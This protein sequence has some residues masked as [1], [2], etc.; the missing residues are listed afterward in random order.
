MITVHKGLM[1]WNLYKNKYKNKN[2]SF[3]LLE[4][5]SLPLILNSGNKINT[6]VDLSRT[7][8]YLQND[9]DKIMNTNNINKD[10]KKINIKYYLSYIIGKQL[11]RYEINSKLDKDTSKS[12]V[13][14]KFIDIPN[15]MTDTKKQQIIEET[16]NKG[17][18]K[19][20]DSYIMDEYFAEE[21][22]ITDMY[23][24]IDKN[25]KLE[26]DIN[27]LEEKENILL[28]Q[29]KD[30][31]QLKAIDLL[32]QI[33]E[34]QLAQYKHSQELI[35]KDN[36]KNRLL[37]EQLILK[38][39]EIIKTNPQN[40]SVILKID[41]DINK[42]MQIISERF[43]SFEESL[44]HQRKLEKEI[45]VKYELYKLDNLY[46]KL[47]QIQHEK[48]I[49]LKKKSYVMA[50]ESKIGKTI[51]DEKMPRNE[52]LPIVNELLPIVKIQS[53]LT[54]PDNLYLRGGK[55]HNNCNCIECDKIYEQ[56]Y[57]KYKNKYNIIKNK[58]N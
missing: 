15:Q 49:I 18:K 32:L 48:E 19:S 6:I 8:T 38:K 16:L 52:Q 54:L 5:A 45:N 35:L 41:E 46:K 10:T 47:N 3:I 13:I 1:M 12:Y 22:N 2:L 43:K 14:D 4:D 56:K 17:D 28:K 51:Y 30:K 57:L 21:Q 11:H 39:Q 37:Y 23:T 29:I 44:E 7:I 25:D 53:P 20:E 31:E 34:E 40:I 33:K 26:E 24:I 27:K 55:L 50:N 36:E 9:L 58:L 42:I